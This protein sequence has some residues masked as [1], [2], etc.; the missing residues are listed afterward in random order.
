MEQIVAAATPSRTSSTSPGPGMTTKTRLGPRPTGPRA[1]RLAVVA[2]LVATATATATATVLVWERSDGCCRGPESNT[3]IAVIP[4][5]ERWH[6]CRQGCTV[7][8]G[9]HAYEHDRPGRICTLWAAAPARIETEQ[10]GDRTVCGWTTESRGSGE[11]AAGGL[12]TQATSQAQ[13][14]T[15]EGSGVVSFDPD[16]NASG[17]GEGS[18]AGPRDRD[19]DR[20]IDRDRDDDVADLTPNRSSSTAPDISVDTVTDMVTGG[21][22]DSSAETPPPPPPPPLPT[23]N[24]R[25][26]VDGGWSIPDADVG[27]FSK[28][29][30]G[31]CRAAGR[32]IQTITGVTSLH[33][34]RELCAA[35]NGGVHSICHSFEFSRG[36]QPLCDLWGRAPGS[37]TRTK[38]CLQESTCS[39]TQANR[40]AWNATSPMPGLAVLPVFDRMTA[41]CCRGAGTMLDRRVVVRATPYSDTWCRRFCDASP[42]CQT[43]EHDRHTGRC[44]LWT[45]RPDA[46][47]TRRDKGCGSPRTTKCYWTSGIHEA[48]VTTTAGTSASSDPQDGTRRSTIDAGGPMTTLAPTLA[49]TS[50]PT[51]PPTSPPTS[52]RTISSTSSPTDPPTRMHVPLPSN[53]PTHLLSTDLPP[54]STAPLPTSLS[55]TEPPATQGQPALVPPSFVF[56]LAVRQIRQYFRPFITHFSG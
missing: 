1:S 31:C 43:Y 11:D 55:P 6:E 2:A 56:I 26:E 42:G 48:P 4:E 12:T 5:T 33:D 52:A 32:R 10:C 8:P 39:W 46:V 40:L 34:C 50:S 38:L 19:R 21:P 37:I 47:G 44:E 28:R 13:A 54:T 29:A 3:V 25:T 7:Y 35:A 23:D 9:C 20:D 15:D 49:T 24:V 27:L 16:G 17:S 14:T 30:S 53:P 41:G 51:D 45:E 18:G 22:P 36:V